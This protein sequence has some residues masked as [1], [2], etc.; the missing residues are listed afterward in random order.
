MSSVLSFP[1]R[2]QWGDARYRGNCS[3]HVYKSLFETL[4]P[5]SF[6]DPMMGSG[7]SIEVAEQMG[8]QAYGLD[9]RLGFNALRSSIVEAIGQPV[10]L[11]LSHPPYGDMIRYSGEVWGDQP[12]PD[13]LSWCKNDVDFHDKL[14]QVLLNQREATKGGGHYG[15][16]IG[17]LRARDRYV[18]Y[19]AEA[20]ARMPSDELVAVMIK[21]QWNCQS[22]AKKYQNLRYPRILH[23]Y[24]LLWKK[25]D[26]STFVLLSGMANTADQRLKATWRAIVHMAMLKL[27]G[28]AALNDIYNAV[29]DG[30]P[31]RCETNPNW[32]AKVRQTLQQNGALF[33]SNQ[34]GIWSLAPAIT[35]RQAA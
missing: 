29:F 35:N 10:D 34:R 32:E 2:G 20:I 16:I 23:E 27:H 12:H 21:Q 5:T 11:V 6:C 18:S 22:D 19:Q 31:G 1:D 7:T 26:R 14:Q 28:E 8:I 30:A 25:R 9:L 15:T 33:Q 24:I 3:G 13:D 4:K 17:D